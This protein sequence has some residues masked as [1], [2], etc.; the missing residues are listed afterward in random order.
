LGVTD[1]KGLIP[2]SKGCVKV[3]KVPYI[4]D[5]GSR[6]VDVKKLGTLL[7]GLI[8][9]AGAEALAALRKAGTGP[10][11]SF[12]AVE[13]LVDAAIKGINSTLVISADMAP[14]AIQKFEAAGV[15]YGI[16]DCDKK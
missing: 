15:S 8:G 6:A 14:Q 5:G 2:M 10:D 3:I 13:A 7:N 9:V 12:G 1:L 11:V 4:S 16:I